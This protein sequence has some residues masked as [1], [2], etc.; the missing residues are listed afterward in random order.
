M[1]D[2]L[3]FAMEWP[4]PPLSVLKAWIGLE[5]LGSAR[6]TYYCYACRIYRADVMWRQSDL[7]GDF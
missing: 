1:E 3:G 4:I 7:K 6:A 2:F 5:Q